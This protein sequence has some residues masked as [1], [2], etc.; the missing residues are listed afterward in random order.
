MIQ[1]GYGYIFEVYCQCGQLATSSFGP[2]SSIIIKL[3]TFH[4][5]TCQVRLRVEGWKMNLKAHFKSPFW[6]KLRRIG[7][8][9]QLCSLTDPS[10][11][12]RRI[13]MFQCIC[14]ILQIHSPKKVAK[15]SFHLAVQ[16]SSGN[17][18]ISRCPSTSTPLS[19]DFTQKYPK[20]YY[21]WSSKT[22][23]T[24]DFTRGGP[25]NSSEQLA[26]IFRPAPCKAPLEPSDILSMWPQLE[27]GAA[28][29][30]ASSRDSQ[31][32]KH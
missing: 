5:Q 23:K 16:E 1:W 4:C 6:R 17:S 21:V 27:A 22:D 24:G 28:V 20:F 15:V 3:W 30:E 13:R 8:A 10:L 2:S 31:K 19:G 7:D 14:R 11:P 25:S 18:G 9:A 32:S 26:S 12:F 29:D